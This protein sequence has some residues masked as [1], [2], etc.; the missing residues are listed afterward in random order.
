M[1]VMVIV[2][3]TSDSEAGILPS[4][5]MFEAMGKYNEELVKAG[6]MLS[7]DGLQPSSKGVRVHFSGKNR[8]V[9]KGPFKNTEELIAGFW[10]W[11]VT[12]MEEAIE[13]VKRAPNPM[14]KDSDIDI[15]PFYEL[16]DFGDAITPEIAEHEKQLRKK[17]A[18][19]S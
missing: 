19:R 4:T 1:K 12:S 18:A 8:T 14:L 16:E 10:I 7:G 15:R 5:E 11:Q 2:K 9:S 6:I 17:L 13:W 3:A